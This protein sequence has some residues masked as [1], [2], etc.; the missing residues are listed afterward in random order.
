MITVAGTLDVPEGDLLVQEAETA[1]K[2]APARLEIDL[3]GL[4]SYTDKGAKALVAC[5]TLGARLPEGL[6]YRTGRGPGRD[7]L[8][9]A[10]EG[11]DSA[12][13]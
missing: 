6:H 9:A 11:G 3:R 12:D 4:E 1:V 10:Y 5:R 7:A 8:L 13:M 2:A